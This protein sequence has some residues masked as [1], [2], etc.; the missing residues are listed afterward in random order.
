MMSYFAK[1]SLPL[2]RKSRVLAN[3]PSLPFGDVVYGCPLMYLNE[4]N[5]F[6]SFFCY[7]S[8]PILLTKI[9]FIRFFADSQLVSCDLAIP[10]VEVCYGFARQFKN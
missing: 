1:L 5:D 9:S 4:S 8:Q 2:R 7:R 3:G 10:K 6:K